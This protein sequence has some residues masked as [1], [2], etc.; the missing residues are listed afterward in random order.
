MNLKKT[1]KILVF[2][3]PLALIYVWQGTQVFKLAYQM[4]N[5][6]CVYKELLEKNSILRYNIDVKISSQE[7]GQGFLAKDKDLKIA[8]SVFIVKAKN[9]TQEP[10]SIYSKLER[11][12][13]L[14]R[15]FN[16]PAEAESKP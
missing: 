10:N 4:E 13:H 15:F 8:D 1:L 7:M 3:L 2:L 9:N 12:N 14:L 11:E 16:P 5:K 6:V